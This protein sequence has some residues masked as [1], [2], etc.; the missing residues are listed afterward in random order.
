MITF[1]AFTPHSPLLIE[2]IGKENTKALQETRDAMQKLSEELYASH[3]D[4]ILTIST[5]RGAHKDAF[6]LNL[7][8]EY[9]IDFQ[10]FGDHGSHGEYAPDLE[11]MTQI[12]RKFRN[13]SIPFT[14]DSDSNLDYGIGVPL[15]LLA[16][17]TKSRSIIPITYSLLPPKTQVQ[18]GR[19]LKDVCTASTKRIA[20]IASGDLSHT[21]ASDAPAGFHPSGEEVDKLVRQSIEHMSLSQLLSIDEALLE[22]SQE[23]AH[24]PLLILFGILEKMHVRP[25]ILSYEHPFGVGQLVAQFH[26]S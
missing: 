22:Q 18:F 2:S 25:E 6:S 14:L 10:E 12:Q 17:N 15:A 21:L 5:H 24:R 20:I 26:L 3:P 8:D 13:E 11:L 7:H 23:C 9:F 4:V 1:A 16:K 19:I